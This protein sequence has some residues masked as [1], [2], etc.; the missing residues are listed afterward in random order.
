MQ[1]EEIEKR[2]LGASPDFPTPS[3]GSMPISAIAMRSE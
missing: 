3:P 1:L 2:G